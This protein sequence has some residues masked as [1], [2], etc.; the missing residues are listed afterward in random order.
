VL[1]DKLLQHVPGE[2][3]D[4]QSESCVV[5]AV[6]GVLEGGCLHC[7]LAI[8]LH[9]AL[10][11]MYLRVCAHAHACV[12]AFRCSFLFNKVVHIEFFVFAGKR[13]A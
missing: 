13:M 7:A 4:L 9:R 1:L 12:R 6:A 2:N 5:W 11:C 10:A 3:R 8:C